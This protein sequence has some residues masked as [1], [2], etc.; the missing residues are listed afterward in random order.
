MLERTEGIQCD[1]VAWPELSG[2]GVATGV[3]AEEAAKETGV[4]TVLGAGRGVEGRVVG[5]SS[6][7]HS[8]LIHQGD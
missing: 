6:I 5:E 2:T 4:C 3:E 8:N 7:Y 1:L